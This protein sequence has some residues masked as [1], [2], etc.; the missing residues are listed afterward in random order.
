M[1][2]NYNLTIHIGKSFS[3]GKGLN[4]GFCWAIPPTLLQL[5]N[6]ISAGVDPAYIQDEYGDRQS[7][8]DFLEQ[9]SKYEPY[10]DTIGDAFS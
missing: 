4:P 5:L 3:R 2:T 9:V 8:S 7:L 10:R 6:D 1:G